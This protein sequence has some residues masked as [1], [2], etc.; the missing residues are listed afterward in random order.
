MVVRKFDLRVGGSIAR[1]KLGG[2]FQSAI[3]TSTL[4][5]CGAQSIG[6]H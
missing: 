1:N 4:C 2:K 5:E 3:T 6:G